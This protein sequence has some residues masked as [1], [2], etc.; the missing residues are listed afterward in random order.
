M[1]KKPLSTRPSK[2]A[3]APPVPE[4]GSG[5]VY[6][7]TCGRVMCTCFFV[8]FSS[9]IF[10]L[11]GVVFGEGLLSSDVFLLVFF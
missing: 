3:A 8:F 6:C 4:E 11:I 9:G 7:Y 1:T 2:N 10:V 5:K